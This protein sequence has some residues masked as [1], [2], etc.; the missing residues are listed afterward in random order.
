MKKACR[1]CLLVMTFSLLISCQSSD[2]VF[3]KNN[4]IANYTFVDIPNAIQNNGYIYGL[5]K[6]THDPQY[7]TT[8]VMPSVES[9][10]T[11]PANSSLTKTNFSTL[12]QWLGNTTPTFD[13]K[14]KVQ[15]G[16]TVTMSL[17]FKDAKLVKTPILDASKAIEDAIDKIRSQLNN[18]IQVDE[19]DFF[20]IVSTIK[21]KKL[22]YVFEKNISDDINFEANIDN[23]AKVSPA[24]KLDK[25]KQ[26]RLEFDSPDYRIVLYSVLP[27]MV[28]HS[29]TGEYDVSIKKPD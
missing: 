13:A 6:K 22:D 26:T 20:L 2:D 23:I 17:E 9:G 5:N 27:L 16:S 3:K 21:A 19:Y 29:L 8:I 11:L 10:V 1:Q 12:L 28:N 14:G 7:L 24:L 4:I 18:I 15:L 25:D